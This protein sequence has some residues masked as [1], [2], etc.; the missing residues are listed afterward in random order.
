MKILFI[1]LPLPDHSFSYING[2]IDYAAASLSGFIRKYYPH[3]SCETLPAVLSN[4]CSDKLILRY[5]QGTK[6]D[7]I[8]FTS[9]LWNIERNL[10]LAEKIKEIMPETA[11]IF[12]GPEIAEGSYSLAEQR[13]YVDYFIT[14]E[15]E[16]FFSMFLTSITIPPALINQNRLFVQPVEAL[17]E[18]SQIYEPLTGMRLN[19]NNDSSIFIELTRGC[20][21]RCSYCYYSRNFK[22][23]RELPFNCLVDSIRSPMNF[24]EIYILSPTFDRSSDFT[25]KLRILKN[26]DH[27]VKLHTEIRTDRIDKKT[28]RLMFDA[29][30]RSLEVGLQSM[31][32]RALGMINRDSNT[33]NELAGMRHLKEAGIEL[34]I[35]IIPGLPGDSPENFL[36]TVDILISNELGECIELYPLMILP[37]T[38]IRETAIEHGA[39]FQEKPPYYFQ[40]GWNFSA[41][42][43]RYISD[44]VENKTGL[45]HSLFFLPDFTEPENYIFTKGV[46]FDGDHSD[47]WDLQKAASLTDRYV[48]DLHINCTKSDHLYA[49]FEKLFSQ[50]T[51]VGLRL[52]NLIIYSDVIINENILLTLMRKY[53]TDNLHKRLNVF[54]SEP[55]TSIVRFFQVTQN[56][57]IHKVMDDAYT[58]ITPVY[59]ITEKSVNFTK[60]LHN[61]SAVLVKSGVYGSVS[62]YLKKVYVED[63]QFA[64]FQNESEMQQFYNDIGSEYIKLPYNFGLVKA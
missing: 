26:L 55:E 39:I 24:K 32:K 19:S 60:V 38:Q 62:S 44:Y 42:D 14:G 22:K 56:L 23:V 21:Y 30:F 9:Y 27:N 63:P 3:V 50:M 36:Q 57:N 8:S 17:I 18:T 13:S 46:N 53:E 16:W 34:Q 33:E 58:I 28:A 20:P 25:D 4:F 54:H 31:N 2:N 49:G 48:I 64:A 11:I 37:G 51:S 29:G 35:G 6:P 15:G 52:I 59:M 5:I 10:L 1:Q 43:I 61:E 12:G 40:S 7:V 45:S 41:D 47:A